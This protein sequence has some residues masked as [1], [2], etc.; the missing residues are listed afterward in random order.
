VILS[1]TFMV[2]LDF[3]IVNVAIPSL[4]VALHATSAAIQLVVA[5]YGLALAI[6]LITAGRLGD[7]Y[8]RR[9]VFLIGL[10]LFTLTS[11]ACGMAPT[12]TILVIARVI[13]GLA[14]AILSPQILAMV[15]IVYT[16]EDRA[17]AFTVYGLALGLAAVSGQL[18]G[19]LLIAANIAGLAWRTCFL[20]NVPLGAAAL[21]LTPRLL[22]ESRAEGRSQLDLIGAALVTLGLAT[23]VLPLIYGRAQDWPLWTWLSL[24]VSLPLLMAFAGYQRWL[25][26]RG[27]APLIALALFRERAFVIGLLTV[28]AFY[29]GMASFF[30]ALALYLQHGRG[31]SALAAGATFSALGLGYLATSLYAQRLTQRLGRQTLTVGAL[32]MAL[33]LTLL[34]VTVAE[35]GMSGPILL[36]T[37][38]LLLDGA[39]MGMVL[40]P[41]TNAVLASVAPKYAGATAGVLSTMIQVGNALGVAILG[42]IFFGVLGETSTQSAYSSAFNASLIYLVFLAVAVAALLQILPRSRQK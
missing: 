24:V 13:Q 15:G 34:G 26:A 23:I 20:I 10:T 16:G 8:G 17:R 27:G 33:G 40:A 11:A 42:I 29:A 3:F 32:G 30:L 37:P 1:G 41:L 35:I 28:L 6:G 5:G 9:R 7:L 18:I 38:A 12:P 31:L 19:G 2:T 22:P 39:G 36:L 14:A 21:F 4:Q 25:G